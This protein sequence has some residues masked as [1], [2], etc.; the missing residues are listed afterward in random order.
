M[1]AFS[2]AWQI[3]KREDDY[4]REE[5]ARM[6]GQHEQEIF[7]AGADDDAALSA[8]RST[9]GGSWY[10]HLKRLKQ[11]EEDVFDEASQEAE[12]SMSQPPFLT[13]SERQRAIENLK[14]RKRH[15]VRRIYPPMGHHD[16]REIDRRAGSLPE[17]FSEYRVDVE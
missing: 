17:R 7:G 5:L 2:Q 14:W 13:P 16:R 15:A 6:G 12:L 11:R 8:I 3:L 9:D 10:D 1:S 4:I